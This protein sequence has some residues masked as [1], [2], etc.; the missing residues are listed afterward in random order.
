M[1]PSLIAMS[2]HSDAFATLRDCRALFIKHLGALLRIASWFP[3]TPSRPSRKAQ[4]AYF[5]EIVASERRGNFAEEAYG[6]TA[7]R[8]TLLA[9]D[10]LEL[11][12]RLDNLTARLL[13]NAGSSLWK[14]HLRFVTLLRRP[15]LSNS[16]NPVGP[17]GI[18]RGAGYHVRRR[19]RGD[20]SRRQAGLA[21]SLRKLP[22]PE[23]ARPLCRVERFSDRAVSRPRQ[24]T[25]VTSRIARKTAREL[26]ATLSVNALQALQQALLANLPTQAG[27]TPLA[28]S[29]AAANLLSQSALEQLMFRLEALERM[30]RFG[31][32]VIPGSNP[33]SEP[34]MPALFSRKRRTERT[35]DHS[36]GRARHSENGDRAWPSTPW[37]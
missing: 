19:S 22:A 7:S 30:G 10:D 12:I 13:E 23:P 18:C 27:S 21:R 29:G 26:P 2:I 11:G 14:L 32:P 36:F 35:E 9:E 16:D 37:P 17:K 28:G 34:M 1:R 15:D 6:L 5:D 4:G 25:I 8:I 24:P 33:A 20:Q 3:A 31:P